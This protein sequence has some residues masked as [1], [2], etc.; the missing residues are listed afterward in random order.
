MALVVK[1]RQR[2]G[3]VDG[4]MVKRIPQTYMWSAAREASVQGLVGEVMCKVRLWTQLILAK[5]PFNSSESSKH[6]CENPERLLNPPTPLF[7]LRVRQSAHFVICM[8]MTQLIITL[9]GITHA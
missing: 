3:G 6:L 2:R 7:P 9:R 4:L 5:T 8:L 1:E